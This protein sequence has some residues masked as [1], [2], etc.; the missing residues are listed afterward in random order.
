MDNNLEIF[1]DQ[2]SVEFEILDYVT[3]I[4]KA[5]DELNKIEDW[6]YEIKYSQSDYDYAYD[7]MENHYKEIANSFGCSTTYKDG[8]F[9][10]NFDWLDNWCVEFKVRCTDGMYSWDGTAGSIS[11]LTKQFMESGRYDN[12]F[13]I[14]PFV[15]NEGVNEKGLA[16]GI[17]VVP[18]ND[19][20]DGEIFSVPTTGTNPQLTSRPVCS[21]MLVKVLL[22]NCASADEA[23]NMIQYDLN[24]YCPHTDNLDD[25]MHLFIADE[26]KQYIVE[27]IN[28]ETV[29][30]DVTGNYPWMTNYYRS[31]AEFDDDGK[32]LWQ[33]LTDHATGTTRSDIIA[34]SYEDITSANDMRNLMNNSLKFTQAYEIPWLDEFTGN[35]DTY[36][37]LTIGDVYEHPEKFDELMIRVQYLY[38]HRDRNNPVTWQTEH[39]CVYDI[40]NHKLYIV[41][42]ESDITY[43]FDLIHEQPIQSVVWESGTGIHSA[44]LKDST[45]SAEGNY[46]VAE[47][48]NTLAKSDYSHT[49]GWATRT[50]VDPTDPDS[51]GHASHAEGSHTIA[52]GT[53]SHAEGNSCESIGWYSHA[54]G[55]GSV[56]GGISSHTEGDGTITN[57]YAEHAEGT[58][59]KSNPSSSSSAKDGT[60]HSVG[61]G[62]S[63]TDRKN[64]FEI[65]QNGDIYVVGI[66]GYDGTNPSEA[67][68][69]QKVLIDFYNN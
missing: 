49:E 26:N 36:G 41:V 64:A 66:G 19:T 11:T 32:V 68:T 24:V 25:E 42:Q 54:E 6:L 13:K 43:E 31:G 33:S 60:L 59:N 38:Q 39:S 7:F 45:S 16:V 63:M 53:A 3:A 20:K 14:V 46:S 22:D 48:L 47:G 4:E 50:I 5:Y 40:P 35:Y 56:S 34:E 15:V 21:V 58:Y 65:M 37:D 61:I 9:G 51:H 18:S 69:L 1:E 57:N 67:D 55:S 28:N 10:K 2:T 17:N 44:Q 62:T 8:L 12:I 52:K 27:F 23:V 29:V 30:I